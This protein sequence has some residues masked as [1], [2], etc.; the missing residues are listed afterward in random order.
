[1]NALMHRNY[2]TSYA[3]TR[4]IWFDD[5]IEV[6]NPGGPFGQVRDDN[7]DRVTDYRNPSLA[8]ALK[9]LGYVNRFGRGIGRVRAALERN[10]NPPPEF[11]VDD[12]SWAVTLRRAT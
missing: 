2:E 1:M 9:G 3:P 8:A 7:F 10:G 12:S 5:R 6:T 4:I 11:Q